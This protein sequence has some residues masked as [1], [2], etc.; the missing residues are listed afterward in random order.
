[1]SDEKKISEPVFDHDALAILARRRRLL[2]SAALSLA[3]SCEVR[4]D[5]N[6]RD[7]ATTPTLT[8]PQKEPEAPATIPIT[9]PTEVVA[10]P[11]PLPCLSMKLCLTKKRPYCLK[12]SPS[13][14]GS[15]L[16]LDIS[17]LPKLTED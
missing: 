17:P 3:I 8:L 6:T 13:L 7:T 11:A 2:A 12:K 14:R 10:P 5:N 16:K 4:H 15:R 1:M 9:Q